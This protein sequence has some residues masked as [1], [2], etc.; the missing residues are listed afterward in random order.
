MWGYQNGQYVEL[1]ARAFQTLQQRRW[2][3]GGDTL[4]AAVGV[5]LQTFHRAKPECGSFS[6]RVFTERRRAK[7][8]LAQLGYSGQHRLRVDV[9]SW[10]TRRISA[11]MGPLQAETK[12]R[13]RARERSFRVGD[14][15]ASSDGRWVIFPHVSLLAA[16]YDSAP[17]EKTRLVGPGHNPLLVS[18]GQITTHRAPDWSMQYRTRGGG[19]GG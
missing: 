11:E 16:D 12:R 17:V 18:A 19:A 3:Q 13:W 15:D 5:A 7:R 9:P 10:W 14:S 1:F 2:E 8:R 4:Q 6:S